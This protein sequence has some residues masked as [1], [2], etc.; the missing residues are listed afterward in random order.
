MMERAWSL[1]VY[2]GAWL[3]LPALIDGVNALV[4][5]VQVGIHRWR[6][7][8]RVAREPAVY[9]GISI[10]VPVYNG[11]RTLAGCLGS[12]RAQ[13]YPH[14]QLEIIVVD[15]GSTD[16]TQEIYEACQGQ[17]FRGRMH[18]LS[19]A[20][21]GKSYALNAGLHVAG[22]P[23]IC[24]IDADAVVHP[25]A[26]RHMARHF[27]SDSALAAATGTVEVLPAEE[28]I[29][30]DPIPYLI[31]E[32]EFQEY[33]SAFWLGRQGQMLNRSMFTLA[34]VF[35]FFRR[36]VLLNTALYDKQTVSEDTK[37]TFD[38]RTQF[39]GERLAC[40]PEAVVY[41]T[42]TPS[43]G[44]LYSQRVRWQRGELEVAAVHLDL[45]DAHVLRMRGLALSR[46]VLIDH[47][48]LF[49]RLVWTFLFP[50]LAFFGYP[51][52]LVIEA[53]GLI[54]LFYMGIAAISV[55]AVYVMATPSIRT[56]L[57]QTWWLVTIVP[58][59]RFA[60][61]VFRLAGSIIAVAEPAEWRVEPPWT[62]VR[63]ALDVETQRIRRKLA[64]RRGGS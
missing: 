20:G 37:I 64:L 42:P 54:Y 40:I 59:Y 6:Q 18:W 28:S 41:V 34:G 7:R 60:I 58:A 23:Y 25:D 12:L 35:S 44:A 26:M 57:R 55:T 56:R 10:I 48:F 15:N 39:G 5:L 2:W 29:D 4:L 47:T 21:R 19:I 61:F 1:A 32:C 3:L 62:E 45:L 14:E 16:R 49:P 11:E 63:Q 43:L 24:T 8:R 17:A 52:S 31:A 38:I 36:D 30:R 46:I 22:H 33:L 13:N 27:E 51:L 53:L 9:P 50:A